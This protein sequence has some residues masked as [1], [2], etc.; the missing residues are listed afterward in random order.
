MSLTPKQQLFADYYLVDLNATQAAI[1]AGYSSRTA[2]KQGSETLRIGKVAAYIEQRR[3]EK[4]ALIQIDRK[5]V[6]DRWSQLVTTDPSTL[7]ATKLGACRFC[8]GVD[9]RYQWTQGEWEMRCERAERD[10]ERTG[11][12]EFEGLPDP[13]GGFGYTP[14]RDPHPDCPECF[15]E[16]VARVVVGNS[17]GNP[18]YAGAKRTKEGIEVKMHDQMKALDNIAKN[19]GM[20]SENVNLTGSIEVDAGPKSARALAIAAMALFRKTIESDK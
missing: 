12:D 16:G 2:A 6:L 15:G 17:K 4:S 1:K 7:A 10:A 11:G 19:L 20:L 18:L 13:A 14:K 3:T 5:W 8:H 9:H